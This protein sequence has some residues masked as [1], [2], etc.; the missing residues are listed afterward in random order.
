V[1]RRHFVKHASAELGPPSVE[2]SY[3]GHNWK[4]PQLHPASTTPEPR[5][6]TPDWFLQDYR[7]EGALSGS[8]ES[9]NTLEEEEDNDTE[10]TDEDGNISQENELQ[11]P[12]SHT[13]IYTE[14]SSM[15][16]FPA[17]RSTRLRNPPLRLAYRAH[18]DTKPNYTWIPPDLI[19]EMQHA[20][21][22]EVDNAMG[23]NTADPHQFY[24]HR[25]T[26]TK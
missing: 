11:N 14:T 1:T 22:T 4:T 23:F 6:Q 13:N 24:R 15:T 25:T 2:G 5:F 9:I 8:E 10:D 7:P 16:P 21:A 3:A 26:G 19:M 12:H 18:A 17:R 20:Y